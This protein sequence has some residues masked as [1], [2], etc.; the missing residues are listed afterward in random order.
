MP[1]PSHHN[2]R[3]PDIDARDPR[4]CDMLY[5]D[6]S[7]WRNASREDLKIGTM[8]QVCAGK[9]IL[10]FD[11][12]G[13]PVEHITRAGKIAVKGV[14]SA[15]GTYCPARVTVDECHQITEVAT[16]E[17][18]LE[19]LVNVTGNPDPQKFMVLCIDSVDPETKK[20]HWVSRPWSSDKGG[21][22]THV[23]G[24]RCITATPNPITQVGTIELDKL[25]E[26]D[27][28]VLPCCASLVVNECGLV[29]GTEDCGPL[30]VAGRCIEV[31]PSTVD[32]SSIVALTQ[33]WD[34]ERTVLP[35]CASLVVNECGLVT[36]TEDC[37]PLVVAGRCI[38]VTPSTVDCSSIV[39]LTQY[40]DTERTVLPCCASLVVNE[41]GLVTGTEDCGPLV[42]AGRCI[43][44]TP[45]TVDC[46]SIVA[47]TQYWDTERTVLPCCASLVVNECGLVTGTDDCGPLVVAG[48]CIEVTPSTVDCSSIVA[49]TQHWDTERTVL[50]CC[51]SLVVNECGIVTGTDDCGPLVEAGRCIEVTPSTDDNSPCAVVVSLPRLSDQYTVPCNHTAVVNEC[52]LVVDTVRC[53]KPWYC[54]SNWRSMWKIDTALTPALVLVPG[55]LDM[56]GLGLGVGW[57]ICL[58]LLGQTLEV[59]DLCTPQCDEDG[60]YDIESLLHVV[61]TNESVTQFTVDALL[62][63]RFDVESDG[64]VWGLPGPSSRTA[65]G[66]LSGDL[67]N[68][69]IQPNSAKH[70]CVKFRHGSAF[71]KC[72]VIRLAFSVVNELLLSGCAI[73]VVS[74]R[75]CLMAANPCEPTIGTADTFVFDAF[76]GF[77]PLSATAFFGNVDA[78]TTWSATNL[79]GNVMIDAATGAFSGNALGATG[80]GSFTV[81]ASNGEGC[82]RTR[83][84]FWDATAIPVALPV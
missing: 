48:R 59:L 7:A 41:C 19:D 63:V 51:A 83:L 64:G 47:L 24:G 8:T 30:V 82:S 2:H 3:C 45:S 5:Y 25:W 62:C 29:T 61:V 17:M 72:N 18:C 60:L 78:S 44:V 33:H 52:G 53:R 40:W 9:G 58:P 26:E 34:A 13:H 38:E 4:R 80:T 10:M 69:V 28:T 66:E 55:L 23:Y 31:T 6:G 71:S 12:H 39:A 15:P 67:G 14:D 70:I 79:P 74:H 73:H 36:G 84:I 21:T 43:E 37:G 46:S 20:P 27:R 54:E 56:I 65:Y 32:C 35:C 75:L 57:N 76:G 16:C 22:V 77:S 1:I 49:L 50:P 11:K 81:T 68:I 42:V